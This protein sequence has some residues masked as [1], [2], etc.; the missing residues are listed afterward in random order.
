MP[1]SITGGHS[2]PA[3]SSSTGGDCGGQQGTPAAPATTA[4]LP[5]TSTTTQATSGSITTGGSHGR[6]IL[7][8]DGASG[9]P[10]SSSTATT[11]ASL[12][13]TTSAT[14]AP[15]GAS[16]ASHELPEA[17]STPLAAP[18]EPHAPAGASSTGPRPGSGGGESRA[19]LPSSDALSAA[20][21]L[22]MQFTTAAASGFAR[23]G[24][25]FIRPDS[26]VASSTAVS[27]PVA[28]TTTVPAS[29]QDINRGSVLAGTVDGLSRVV[30]LPRLTDTELVRL[31]SLLGSEAVAEVLRPEPRRPANLTDFRVQVALQREAFALAE[32]YGVEELAARTVN[33]TRHLL[34]VV[35]RL[36]TVEQESSAPDASA[37][38]AR[39]RAERDRLTAKLAKQKA[40]HA[41]SGAA[42]EA[43][44]AEQILDLPDSASGFSTSDKFQAEID[45]LRA[46]AGLLS[47]DKSDLQ[48]RLVASTSEV[49]ELQRVQDLRGKQIAQLEA[50]LTD[51]KPFSADGLMDFL[52]GNANLS[53]PW[54]RLLELLR[55]YQRGHTVPVQYRTLL[56]VSARDE[57]SDDCGPTCLKKKADT[58]ADQGA[59]S[60]GRS[61][62]D[63]THS[64]PSTPSST[65]VMLY[66][67]RVKLDQRPKMFKPQKVRALKKSPSRVTEAKALSRVPKPYQWEDLRADAR[68]LTLNG[69]TFWDAVA[70][71]RKR[72]MLHDQFGKRALVGMLVSA[73]YWE[74]LDRTPW[75][76]YVPGGYYEAALKQ[77]LDPALDHV[78][79]SWGSLPVHPSPGS[80][81]SQDD[82]IFE[83]LSSDS[84]DDP[85]TDK[86]FQGK[87]AKGPSAVQT[88]GQQ[89][90][91]GGKRSRGSA[92]SSSGSGKA[93]KAS[94]QS[95]AGQTS[96]AKLNIPEPAEDD[97]VIERPRR[98]SW[99]HYGI[100][101]QE[102]LQQTF[103]FPRYM[104]VKSMMKHLHLRW[105]ALDYWRLLRTS[106]WDEMWKG[107]VRSLV[108]FQYGNMQPGMVQA[109]T[110]IA[111]FMSRWRREYWERLHW[112][113]MDPSHDYQAS[114]EMRGIPGLA[115]MYRDR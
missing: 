86:T 104:P 49:A 23:T 71:V 94:A 44:H 51:A 106:P 9:A 43:A 113:T 8:P 54:K 105:R 29:I 70:E 57:D 12:A 61:T 110:V 66:V 47:T 18:G 2:P 58:S 68:E 79:E 24:P 22:A 10:G 27:I 97:G 16:A 89:P 39:L 107:R 60:A 7:A 56:Q 72:Q 19:S 33:T 52:A 87:A 77:I 21:A 74:G 80:P 31:S 20:S 59:G 11:T 62:I 17:T 37:Q 73:I 99:F 64:A 42:L 34:A 55:I 75:T 95:S 14:A 84:E 65:R 53:G 88:R 114:A 3:P 98:G 15:A 76:S 63:L 78:P 103:G 115:E 91:S 35:Q 85:K 101:V 28:T 108:F 36:L 6:S 93:A 4:H 25:S 40:D 69:L 32:V 50:R 96:R 111:N 13:T 46:V 92:G 1:G 41:A 81:P 82:S 90:S 48:D 102:L 100:K 67:D 45:A 38:T 5:A 109:L 83:F 30:P 26:F 112:V